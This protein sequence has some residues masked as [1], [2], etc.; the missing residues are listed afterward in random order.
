M[1]VRIDPPFRPSAALLRPHPMPAWRRMALG[2]SLLVLTAGQAS[3]RVEVTLDTAR[4][5]A[6]VRVHNLME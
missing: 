1:P 2:L 6:R 4:G 3:A 5:G